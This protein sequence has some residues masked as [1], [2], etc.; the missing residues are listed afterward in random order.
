MTNSSRFVT[1]VFEAR[2]A[3]GRGFDAQ[4][5][6]CTLG[7]RKGETDY[8]RRTQQGVQDMISEACADGAETVGHMN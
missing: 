7:E 4:F 2:K 5:F 3:G 6:L 1:P 8:A